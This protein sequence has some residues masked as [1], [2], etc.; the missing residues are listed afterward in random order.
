[1]TALLLWIVVVR[2]TNYRKVIVTKQ[3]VYKVYCPC[4]LQEPI[5][6]PMASDE[7]FAISDCPLCFCGNVYKIKAEVNG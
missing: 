6:V 5:Y 1:M 7:F 2:N 3:L 4:G